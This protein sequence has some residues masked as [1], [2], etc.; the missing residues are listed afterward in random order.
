MHL[1][2]LTPLIQE[3]KPYLNDLIYWAEVQYTVWS[4]QQIQK[5]HE[6]EFH[7]SEYKNKNLSSLA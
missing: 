3:R 5:L 2:T 6:Q 7:L 1:K 4:T